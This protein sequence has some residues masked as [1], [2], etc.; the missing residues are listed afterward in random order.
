MSS[1]IT[2]T[3]SGGLS[4]RTETPSGHQL[5]LDSQVTAGGAG[6]TPMELQLVALGSC[7][8]MDVI[9]IL[10]KMRQ[11]VS[12]YEVRVTATRAA[13]QPRAY[14]TATMTHVLRGRG[15]AEHN[16]RR[17]IGLSMGRYCPVY[18]LL[19]PTVAI[20]ERFEMTDEAGGV[21]VA[22]DVEAVHD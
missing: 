16:V 17:A 1:D 11:D 19:V 5:V 8:A 20:N 4:F 2:L 3:W 15:L 14:L 18:A 9:S 6:P 21:P 13:E 10:Q 7:G 12:A 22:G